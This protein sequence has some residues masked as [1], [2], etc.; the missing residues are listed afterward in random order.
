MGYSDQGD[1]Q[2]AMALAAYISGELHGKSV[3]PALLETPSGQGEQLYEENCVGCHGVDII[4]EWAAGLTLSEI[5]AGLESLSSLNDMMEN[6][7]GTTEEKKQL[8]GFF[9]SPAQAQSAVDMGRSIFEQNCT[10]CHGSDVILAWSEGKSLAAIAE[11][12]LILGKL[13][14]MM[15]GLSLDEDERLAMATWV[16]SGSKGEEQ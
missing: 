7:S 1:E 12:L 10:G 2:E 3:D 8:A 4:Q 5:I 13:N 11:S 15:A 14:P 6:F 16:L 9:Q